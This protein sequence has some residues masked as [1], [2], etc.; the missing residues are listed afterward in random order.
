VEITVV[1][2]FFLLSVCFLETVFLYV[3]QAGFELGILILIP[4]LPSAGITGVYQATV[5][6][7]GSVVWWKKYGS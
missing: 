7:S 2:L 1:N 6:N 5:V 4:S 3:P